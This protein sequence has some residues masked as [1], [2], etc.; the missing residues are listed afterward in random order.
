MYTYLLDTKKTCDS[1]KVQFEGIFPSNISLWMYFFL[2]L[3]KF[4]AVKFSHASATNTVTEK[5]GKTFI[6]NE[7]WMEH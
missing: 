6:L 5:M 2:F 3:L 7:L 4:P 1:R